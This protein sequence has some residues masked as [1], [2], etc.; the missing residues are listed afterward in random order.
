MCCP[1]SS[2][3]LA[4]ANSVGKFAGEHLQSQRA[5]LTRVRRPAG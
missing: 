2:S 1:Q 3:P 5:N 4:L